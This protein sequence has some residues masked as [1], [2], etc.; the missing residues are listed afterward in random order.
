MQPA[1]PDRAVERGLADPQQAGCL[2]GGQESRGISASAPAGRERFDVPLAEPAVATRSDQ[3]GPQQAFGHSTQNGRLA[4]AEASCYILR[5]DQSVQDVCWSNASLADRAPFNKL[6]AW[7][8]MSGAGISSLKMCKYP[9]IRPGISCQTFHCAIVRA[10][11]QKGI[12]EL[13]FS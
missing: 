11:L 2:A 1:A 13:I 10:G 3:D 12:D 5:T 7:N 9:P 4:D 6:K 8:S